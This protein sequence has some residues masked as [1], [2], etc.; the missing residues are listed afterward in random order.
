ME[1]ILNTI[2]KSQVQDININVGQITLAIGYEKDSER[3]GENFLQLYPISSDEAEIL[4]EKKRKNGVIGI[5][6][7]LLINHS[8]DAMFFLDID[9]TL[10]VTDY[11]EEKYYIDAD[12]YLIM[13]L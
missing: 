12:G 7:E 11:H 6:G 13:N 5:E 10:S 4:T 1:S 9:G 2:T 8:K 3:I